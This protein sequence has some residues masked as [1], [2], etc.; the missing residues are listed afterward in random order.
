MSPTV[1]IS[2]KLPA[3]SALEVDGLLGTL[4]HTCFRGGMV[5]QPG[6]AARRPNRRNTATSKHHPVAPNVEQL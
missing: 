2:T 3:P 4:S 1:G 6:A 5:E